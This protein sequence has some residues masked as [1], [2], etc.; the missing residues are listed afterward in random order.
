MDT[1]PAKA[2]RF[3]PCET[4]RMPCPDKPVA[5]PVVLIGPVSVGKSTVAALLAD[6]PGWPN[7]SMDDACAKYHAEIGFDQAESDRRRQTDGMWAAYRYWRPFE[8]YAVER[9]LADHQNAV[10]DLGGGHSVQEDPALLAGVRAAL[11]SVRNVVLLLPSPDPEESVR[12][13]AG[14]ALGVPEPRPRRQ[15]RA[16]RRGRLAWSAR[17]YDSSVAATVMRR[18]FRSALEIGQPFSASSAAAWKASWSRP[19]TTPRTSSAELVT[20]KPPPCLASSDT[21]AVTSSRSGGV[22]PRPSVAENAIA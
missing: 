2:G 16:G 9:I 5:A 18:L 12:I 1:Q 10:I 3:G 19:G 4:D 17:R 22:L 14:C 8:A 15:Y 6:R 11:A 13:L 21:V 7:V 20:S